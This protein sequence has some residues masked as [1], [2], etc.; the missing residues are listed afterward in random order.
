VMSRQEALSRSGAL[1][2]QGAWS[3]LAAL[4]RREAWSRPQAS[5]TRE[6]MSM[7]SLCEGHGT[8]EMCNEE[9][10]STARWYAE[11]GRSETCTGEA[12]GTSRLACTDKAGCSEAAGGRSP[13]GCALA[14]SPSCVS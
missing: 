2:K 7:T 4:N 9:A 6:V 8:V 3:R 5:N 1:S 12:A 14:L 11:Q 13:C 10:P